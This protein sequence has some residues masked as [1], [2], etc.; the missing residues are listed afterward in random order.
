MAPPLTYDPAANEASMYFA[1]A[2]TAHPIVK[3]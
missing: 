1:H 2:Q 3:S